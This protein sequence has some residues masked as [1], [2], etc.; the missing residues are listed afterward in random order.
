MYAPDFIFKV[1]IAKGFKKLSKFPC[2]FWAVDHKRLFSSHERHGLDQAW[3]SQEMV[4]MEM[5][6]KNRGKTHHS[7]FCPHHLLLGALSA[8]KKDKFPFSV[9]HYCR[10][11]SI[12]GRKRTSSTKKNYAKHDELTNT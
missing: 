6:D 11:V 8:V 7:C 10:W 9:D 5:T 2:P 3:N 12:A 1:E 4:R